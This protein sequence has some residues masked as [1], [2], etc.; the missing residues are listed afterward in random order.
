M[1]R[2]I[3]LKLAVAVT[4]LTLLA[5]S[6]Y[7]GKFNMVLN[8]GD[9]APTWAGALGIDDKEHSLNEYKDAKLVVMVFTCNKCPVAVAYEDRLVT[10]QKEYKGKGV[11]FVAVN[12]N[13]AEADG[14]PKMKE[15]A[16]EKGFNFPYLYD[17]T[18]ESARAY[19]A[20]VTPHVFVLDPDRKVTYMG[21]VDDS[22]APDKVTKQYLRDAIDA[23]LAGTSAAV[24]ETKQFGCGIGYKSK[25][26]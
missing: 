13:D 23:A 21:A 20:T 16:E 15:R 4:A 12:V 24:T 10:L 5:S 11:Q 6:S 17:A 26:K 14:L 19:G 22:Q 9:K 8:I 1:K 7:A 18:Q 2:R 25:A 3:G